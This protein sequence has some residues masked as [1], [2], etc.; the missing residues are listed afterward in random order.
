ML[1]NP[2]VGDEYRQEYYKGVAEDMAE[3]TGKGEIIAETS[4]GTFE[5][6]IIT[7]DWTPLEEKVDEEKYYC[8]EVGGLALE[9][10]IYNDERSELTEIKK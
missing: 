8:K 7:H 6:C 4:Y 9:V 1:A 5:N 3:V 2:Q 10:G